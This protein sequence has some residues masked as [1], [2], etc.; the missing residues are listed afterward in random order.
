M[1]LVDE[2]IVRS[3]TSEQIVEIIHMAGRSPSR[4]PGPRRAENPLPERLRHRYAQLVRADCI[5]SH[6]RRNPAAYRVDTLR[7]QDLANLEQAE[8]EDNLDVEQLKFSVFNGIHVTRDVDQRYLDYLESLRNDDSKAL[9]AQTKVENLKIH[10]KVDWYRAG[11]VGC[12]AVPRFTAIGHLY[13]GGQTRRF[14]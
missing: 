2:F 3:T 10:M 13:S 11:A 8:R 6:G 5:W 1:L 4:L 12:A 14:F 9:R 7:F